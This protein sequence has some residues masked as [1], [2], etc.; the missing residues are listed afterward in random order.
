M[1]SVIMGH[2]GSDAV[3]ANSIAVISKNLITCF[4]VGIANGGGILLGNALGAGKLD[5]AREYGDRLM[6]IAVVNGIITGLGLIAVSP[7][8]VRSADLTP[9]AAHYLQVMFFMCGYYMFGK[10]LTGVT[11]AGIFC[12]GGDSKFG[13]VCD[14]IT[15]WCFIVPAGLVTA[16]VLH[17]PVLWVYFLINLDETVKLPA[18]WKHYKKYQW[19]KNITR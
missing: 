5:L 8:I 19:V 14:T 16:F 2:M 17:L 7:L 4:A 18:F 15:M 3:A 1:Q 12:A 6:K 13:F 11:N 10:S 9:M